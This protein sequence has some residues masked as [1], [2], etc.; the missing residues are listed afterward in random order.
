MKTYKQ[1]RFKNNEDVQTINIYK[2]WRYINNEDLQK[3]KIYKQWRCTNNDYIKA[4]KI[5]KQWRYTN[6]EKL[7]TY[8][9]CSFEIQLDTL[10]RHTA[11]SCLKINVNQ[12][13]LKRQKNQITN[14]KLIRKLHQLTGRRFDWFADYVDSFNVGEPSWSFKSCP[15]TVYIHPSTHASIH[16]PCI[17]TYTGKRLIGMV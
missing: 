8:L 14:D 5:Y 15:I 9:Y 10:C 2:Q 6:N 11:S 7:K 4:M 17:Y 1:W 3:M 16:K 12:L 13:F